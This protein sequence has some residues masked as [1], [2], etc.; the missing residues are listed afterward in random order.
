MRK[1][2][3]FELRIEEDDPISGIDSVSLVSDPAIEVNWIAFNKVKQEDFLVPDGE[4]EKYLQMFEGKGHPEQDLLDEGFVVDKVIEINAQTFGLSPTDPNED[5]PED[6]DE[7]RVRYK[8]GLSKNISEEPIILTTREY[9]RTLLNRNYVFRLSEI[10]N[11]PANNDR[12]DGGFGGPAKFFR[13]GF[14]C[15]HR[16]YKILY[17][18]EG[19]IRNKGSIKTNQITDDAGRSV[20]LTPDWVQ[21]DTITRPT[22]EAVAK[23]T[24]SP[25]TARN[26]GLSKQKFEEIDIYGFKPRY[27]HMCPGAIETFKHLISMDNDEDTIGMIRSAAQIADN[28]FRIEEE[29]IKSEE[30]SQDQLDQAMILVDDFVD[31]MG[32]IDEESGMV[33]DVSYMYGH[34]EKIKSYVKE[35]LGYDVGGL[36]AYVDEITTGKT[37]SNF[38]SYNDYPDSV[39]NNACKVL[40]WR[41]EHGDEVK[42]MT[43]VGWTRANQLCKKEKISED[44]IAR[45]AAFERHRKNSEVSPEFKGTPWKD[46]G[47]VAWLGW[48]G[49]TGIEWAKKKLQS[50]RNQKMSKQA[51]EVV[52]SEKRIT[53]GP[54]MIPDLLILR[55]DEFGND[56]YVKFTAE[57]IRM[58]AEKYMRNKYIDNNDTEHDGE[59]VR[60]VYVIESWIKEDE[61]DKSNKYGFQDLPIGTWFVSM[62]IK[63]NDVWERV[64][65]GELR[66]YSVS[67]YFEEIEQFNK[68][69]MFLKELAK[70]LRDE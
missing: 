62:K 40:G 63:N 36:P 2:K 39:S 28:V 61:Q 54:A 64:K 17:K 37:K 43:Q 6:T 3:I 26:L 66:G 60:D 8:Y 55:K 13:G 52:D 42:G 4:D 7:V 31:L 24:A 46:A 67:G 59:A 16:W 68:E 41:D 14:N 12:E 9:C 48:G 58:I 57:T 19:K 5:S 29:V 25:S 15:R 23:G 30:A 69:M 45:M 49:T 32:E 10:D 21:N 44:T 47:Y 22:R 11:L 70:L 50:I 20:E 18:N 33:H 1:D 38:E 27:Y 65:N 34:I 53:V 35:D 56:Y 51:F